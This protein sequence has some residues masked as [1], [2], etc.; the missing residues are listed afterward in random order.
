[1]HQFHRILRAWTRFFNFIFYKHSDVINGLAGVLSRRLKFSMSIKCIL[2]FFDFVHEEGSKFFCQL[3][4]IDGGGM[5]LGFL[6]PVIVLMR[7]KSFLVSLPTSMI[8]E[9]SMCIFAL[10]IIAMYLFLSAFSTVHWCSALY[11]L[12]IC[13]LFMTVCFCCFNS[14]GNHQT[15]V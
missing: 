8:C 12:Q 3:L 4:I 7:P 5:G 1:M 6:L 2:E 15:L 9:D 14:F 10:L 13:S 11:H